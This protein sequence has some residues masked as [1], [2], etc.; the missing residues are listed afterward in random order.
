MCFMFAIA[1]PRLLLSCWFP[2]PSLLAPLAQP[3][4]NQVPPSA[5]GL[6]LPKCRFLGNQAGSTAIVTWCYLHANEQV[7]VSSVNRAQNIPVEILN[8]F[9]GLT[10]LYST[11]A[12]ASLHVFARTGLEKCH[13]SQS[14]LIMVPI[15]TFKLSYE[16]AI[17]ID[18][19]ASLYLP[20][21]TGY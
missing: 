19:S 2:F 7:R 5:M 11:I 12:K 14:L 6:S 17:N 21:N 16:Q 9:P 10:R 8:T 13:F 15:L 1:H 4:H 3:Q 18:I 20:V